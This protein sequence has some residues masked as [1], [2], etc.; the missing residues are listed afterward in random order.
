MPPRRPDVVIATPQTAARRRRALHPPMSDSRLRTGSAPSPARRG[1]GAPRRSVTAGRVLRA[2]PARA[3]RAD[4]GGTGCGRETRPGRR[5]A[6]GACAR[7]PARA[8]VFHR[9]ERWERRDNGSAAKVTRTRGAAPATQASSIRHV[10]AARQES[11]YPIRMADDLRRLRAAL[12]PR[13]TLEHEQG[14]GGMATVYRAHDCQLNRTVAVKV[15]RSDVVSALT[16]ER[17]LREINIACQLTHPH[18]LPVFDS[19]KSG[20]YLYYVMPFVTGG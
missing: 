2:V 12:A 17:F 14:R 8:R 16:A 15:L 3:N 18:V 13:Y 7:A 9:R 4:V 20:G 5:A 10:V 11:P 6:R 19:G 1:D